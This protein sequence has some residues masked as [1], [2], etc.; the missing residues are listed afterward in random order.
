M[1]PSRC[2]GAITFTA[3]A[4]GASA[5]FDGPATIGADGKASTTA[6]AYGTAGTYTVSASAIGITGTAGFRLTNVPL[7]TALDFSN[8]FANAGNLFT[9]NRR[10]GFDG[11]PKTKGDVLE[12]TDGE[13]NEACSAFFTQPVYVAHFSTQFNFQLT[14]GSYPIADG[15]TFCIQGAANTALGDAGGGLG[16]GAEHIGAPLRIPKSVAVKFDLYNNNG[17]GTNSTGL[18]TDGAAPT[19]PAIDL[20]QT[21]INLHSGHV[22]DVGMTY[23][24]STLRVKETDTSTQATATQSYSIDIPTTVGNDAAYVGFTGG[25]GSL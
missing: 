3:P 20:S 2:G 18:Y 22:F 10:P 25:T 1:P 24:G 15:I 11:P 16:Y 8:G 7:A 23:D 13:W 19:M 4:S 21:G 14:A 17:E 6:T 5:A 9:F 12:L